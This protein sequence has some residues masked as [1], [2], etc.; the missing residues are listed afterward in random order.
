MNIKMTTKPTN[1][2]IESINYKIAGK[3][4]DS[5]A[6]IS[7]MASGGNGIL[8]KCICG[9]VFLKHNISMSHNF[10]D[11]EGSVDIFSRKYSCSRCHRIV[12]FNYTVRENKDGKYEELRRMTLYNS[13]KHNYPL[14]FNIAASKNWLRKYRSWGAF[15]RR[16]FCWLL[17]HRYPMLWLV[18]ELKEPEGAGVANVNY[19]CVYCGKSENKNGFPQ[20]SHGV[21]FYRSYAE[22]EKIERFLWKEE[23]DECKCC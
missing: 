4:A 19:G 17:G 21:D 14:V 5:Y 2:L 10:I 22:L 12:E 18:G 20:G 1:L 3:P 6:V 11:E 9:S 16:F 8:D 23:K 7:E 15:F 13:P